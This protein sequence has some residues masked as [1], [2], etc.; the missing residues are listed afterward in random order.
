MAFSALKSPPSLQLSDADTSE[1]TVFSVF[2]EDIVALRRL[3]HTHV[4]I[5]LTFDT[6]PTFNVI[7]KAMSEMEAKAEEKV[8]DVKKDE[9][10]KQEEDE[11]PE[12]IF[13]FV[14][15]LIG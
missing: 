3:T 12:N 4:C 5:H 13:M 1:N 14:P 10:G 7:I 11:K 2:E 6:P 9:E 15:N 8:A